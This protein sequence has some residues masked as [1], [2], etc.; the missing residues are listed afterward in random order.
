MTFVDG[1]GATTTTN[2]AAGTLA[3]G[4]VNNT[5]IPGV[6]MNVGN[7]LVAG[8]TVITT[9][10]VSSTTTNYLAGTLVGGTTNTTLIPGLGLEIDA[11]PAN[12]AGTTVIDVSNSYTSYPAGT[13]VAS[14]SNPTLIEGIGLNVGATL[15]GR[16]R[17]TTTGSSTRG[18]HLATSTIYDAN[19]S[20]H[21]LQAVFDHNSQNLWDYRLQIATE[22]RTTTL[23]TATGETF[24]LAYAPEPGSVKIYVD[25]RDT[26]LKDT[27][28]AINGTSIVPVDLDNDGT[29][30]SPVLA[31]GLDVRIEYRMAESTASGNTGTLEFNE[32][33]IITGGTPQTN[34]AIGGLGIA[35][36][37]SGIV[38][39][40]GAGDAE[41]TA[42]NGYGTGSL[43]GFLVDFE[44]KIIASYSN[45]QDKPLAQ[46][47]LAT[48]G[49]PQGLQ[50]YGHNYLK[51]TVNSGNVIISAPSPDNAGGI[52]HG[53]ALERANVDLGTEMSE[54]LV[55]QRAFQLNSKGVCSIAYRMNGRGRQ[56]G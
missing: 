32:Y 36:D 56:K 7:P 40:H 15:A 48:F 43:E 18:E 51:P 3:A 46:V 30:D 34:A 14:T 55:F 37:F 16:S 25:G 12:P 44:G 22:Q 29:T 50:Q 28:F 33:G 35:V 1:A 52:I 38:Q 19:G 26:P 31:S 54:L 39:F 4:V 5:L 24:T 11:L 20:N 41:G 13:L 9:A 21:Q 10:G 47:A 27:E 23:G 17:I 49:N 45:G 2:M 42:A 6:T 53:S 8:T